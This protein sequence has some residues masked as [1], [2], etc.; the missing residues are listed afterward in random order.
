[1]HDFLMKSDNVISMVN[2]SNGYNFEIN[3]DL[4]TMGGMEGA[5]FIIVSINITV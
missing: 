4:L 1:M 2:N 3:D 5:E